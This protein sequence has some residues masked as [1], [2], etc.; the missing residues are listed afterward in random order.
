MRQEGDQQNKNGEVTGRLTKT[1]EWVKR[2]VS[3]HYKRQEVVRG[4]KKGM[5]SAGYGW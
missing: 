2:F 4:H 1:C 5:R 3:K